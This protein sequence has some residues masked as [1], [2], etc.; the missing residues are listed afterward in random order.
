MNRLTDI[1][2]HLL[3]DMDDGAPDEETTL[4]MLRDAQEQ[5]IRRIYATPHA[6]PGYR[7]FD[8]AKY[9]ERLAQARA[10]CSGHG[11]EIRLLP[12]AEIAWT[13]NTVE[14]LRRK[15]LPTLG[16]TDHVLLE[17]WNGISWHDAIHAVR[18]MN[19]AGY[20]PVL[21]HVE[22]YACF[23]WNPRKALELKEHF[24]VAYQVNASAVLHGRTFMTRRFIK[25][26][27]R[28][29]AIDAVASDAHDC[30]AR[31]QRLGE[32][33]AAL[34]ERCG[35]EYAARLVRYDKEMQ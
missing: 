14:A 13:Y 27:L 4:A 35:A 6:C 20:K 11:I 18:E 17:L 29:Q 3:W 23:R 24:D 22:R 7:P 9:E 1:H 19:R 12:G 25:K 28:E 16:G 31:P 15:R 10:L 26:M 32:A 8:M 21:A 30:G 2:Q 33:Y 34:Q 5:G